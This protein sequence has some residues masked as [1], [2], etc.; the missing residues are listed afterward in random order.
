[1]INMSLSADQKKYIDDHQ[2]TLSPKE[3]AKKLQIDPQVVT[4]YLQS[5]SQNSKDWK[6]R[7]FFLILIVSPIL[8]FIL[9]EGILQLLGYGGNLDLFVNATKDFPLHQMANQ[10]VARRFFSRHSGIPSP[11]IDLFLKQ[12]PANGYRIF[13]LGGS[14]TAGYPYA[15]NL[16]FSRIL[17]RRLNDV[18]PDRKIEVINLAMSAINSYALLDFTDE[19]LENEADLFLIYAG[20]NEYYGALGVASAES[21]G[22]YRPVVMLY[23]KLKNLRSFLLLR[24]VVG[25]MASA[26]GKIL[27][28]ES[29]QDPTAT[30][31]ERLVADQNIVYKSELYERGKRQFGENL[32]AILQKAK[33]RQVPVVLSEL[34]SNLRDQQP[35]VSV[36]SADWP[37]ADQVY[38]DAQ[39]LEQWGDFSQAREKYYLAKDLDALRFRASE[40]FNTIIQELGVEFQL[41]VVPM[42]TVFAEA[43]T[44]GLIGNQLMLEH[45]HPNI[46]GYFLMAEAFFQTIHQCG[47]ISE[48]WDSSKIK[49]PDFYRTHY[50]YTDLDSLFGNLRIHVLRGG[51]PFQPRTAPNK[52]LSDYQPQSKADSLAVRVWSSDSYTL[53]RAHVDL[54]EYYERKNDFWRAFQEYQALI[55]LTPFNVSPYL[56]AADAL[57]KMQNLAGALPLLQESLAI[58]ETVFAHKWIGQI[59]LAQNRVKEAIIHL[60][61]ANQSSPDDLQL[62]YN[63]SGAYAL[64]SQFK[65]SKA[66]LD[67]LMLI[68]P[69][70]PEADILKHQLEGI[71]RNPATD[72]NETQN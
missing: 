72:E 31:M 5:K 54:A 21:I 26:V 33:K 65:K 25:V 67:R 20:H 50:G 58:E 41:P 51:W 63:L 53:E 27:G 34:V 48:Q 43:S 44:N 1:M 38:Q 32:Q 39:Q 60:E 17:D 2:S 22:K 47:F 68:S 62:L 12:K 13:V 4:Q 30:L 40:E 69:N 70:F 16:M 36:S 56:R 46:E 57:L 45:L 24:D 35:F 61:K 42:K 66:V 15:N 37:P 55:H 18:F 52:A 8:F 29:L 49:S 3:L 59:L 19:I 71:L 7:I 28:K 14:T 10:Q 23:L 64:D 9:L 6:N 11:P